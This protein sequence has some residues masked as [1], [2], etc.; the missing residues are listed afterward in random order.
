[1]NNHKMSPCLYFNPSMRSLKKMCEMF[2]KLPGC[3]AGGPLHILLDDDN[4][5]TDSI[6]FCLNES[7][8]HG[9]EQVRTLGSLICTEYLRLN[10]FERATFD[11]YWCGY[12][13]D[14]CYECGNCDIRGELFE[15]MCEKEIEND[16][17]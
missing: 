5:D 16:K 14:C 4:Y 8:Q 15:S 17:T 9:D 10:I 2:Y 1:M 13:M 6:L 7:I 3:G 12:K 11:A